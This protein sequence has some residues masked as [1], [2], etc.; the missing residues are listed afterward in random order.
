MAAILSSGDLPLCWARTKMVAGSRDIA[1]LERQE[2]LAKNAFD[3]VNYKY[4]P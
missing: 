4:L 3:K 2:L 1:E